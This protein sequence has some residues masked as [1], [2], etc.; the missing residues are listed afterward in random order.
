MIEK[1]S[2]YLNLATQILYYFI[3]RELTAV[4][5]Q[6]VITEVQILP[7]NTLFNTLIK[8][9]GPIWALF[10]LE[11]NWNTQIISTLTLSCLGLVL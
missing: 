11:N 6:L 4:I 8:V 10:S 5:D 1:W 9:Y 7:K 3:N 2:K